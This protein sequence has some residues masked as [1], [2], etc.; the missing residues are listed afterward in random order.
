MGE[1]AV[2]EADAA[3]TAAMGALHVRAW[4]AAYRGMMPDP[5]LDG[6][7]AEDRT[8]MWA[9]R[10]ARSGPG[11][12]VGCVDGEV[13]GF[14][15]YG[16]AAGAAV[17]ELYV[18]NVDPA[19]WGCG[20]AR[21]LLAAAVDGLRRRGFDQA[22]LWVVAANTRARRFYEREGWTADGTTMDDDE[23]GV[24]EL[25]YQRPLTP[26]GTVMST[27]VGT[28]RRLRAR[29]PMT[30]IDKRP[31]A[32]IDVYAPG[33]KGSGS[34]VSGDAVVNGRHHGGDDQAVYA[35]AAE[36]LARWSADLGR[37]LAPG[38]FGENLTTRD[39]DVDGAVIGEQWRVGTALLQVTA[40]RI[41][42]RTF[43]DQMGIADWLARFTSRGRTGAYLRVVQPGR[44]SP[45]DAIAVVHR[46]AEGP[47]VVEVFRSPRR[48]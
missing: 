38:V 48:R 15:G 28:A 32:A 26:T 10:L 11:V 19:A 7:R 1:I 24:T 2:R 5:L 23:L 18:L 13:V 39:F 16:A 21:P 8:A 47:T 3:D 44:I 31:A 46:P 20:I 6:L 34:G 25:R 4:Q 9:A 17:G 30:G 27:N 12:L 40:P 45:G 42:C 43:V 41:P 33:P 37:E 22:V 29:G 14:A 36:E 35:F